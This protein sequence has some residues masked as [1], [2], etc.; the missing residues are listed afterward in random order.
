MKQ[1]AMRIFLN[2]IVTVFLIRAF[3]RIKGFLGLKDIYIKIKSLNPKNPL[4]RV[5]AK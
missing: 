2:V 3:T 4:I 5:N 1:V